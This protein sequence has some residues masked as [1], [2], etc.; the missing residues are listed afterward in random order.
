R[1]ARADAVEP[2]AR[3][4]APEHQLPRS[5][6]QDQGR[7]PHSGPSIL[8]PRMSD[9]LKRMADDDEPQQKGVAVERLRA[10]WGRRKWLAV[11]VFAVPCVA[12]V[13]VIFSLPTFYRSQALVLVGLVQVP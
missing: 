2:A 6:L 9:D 10:A 8:E 11:L 7:R 12:A 3:R 4:Q 13:S 1:C 5:A